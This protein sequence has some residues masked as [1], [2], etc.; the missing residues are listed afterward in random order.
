MH[1]RGQVAIFVIIAI[2]LVSSLFFLFFF[3]AKTN[4]KTLDATKKDIESVNAKGLNVHDYVQ[5]LLLREGYSCLKKIGE[6]GGYDSIPREVLIENT[7]Y[8]YYEGSNIQPFLSIIEKEISLCLNRAFLSHSDELLRIFSASKINLQKDRINSSVSIRDNFVELSVQYPFTVSGESTV[9]S[10]SAFKTSYKLN[11]KKIYELGTAVVNYATLPEFDT[12]N[13][14]RCADTQINFTFLTSNG[15]L[16]V[17]GQ[18]F[19]VFENGTVAPYTFMFGIRRPVK[20]AFG[21]GKKHI[22]ILYQENPYL[23]TFGKKATSIFQKDLNI[24]DGAD[25]FGCEDISSFFTKLD[26]YDVVVITGNLQYQIIKHTFIDSSTNKESSSGSEFPSDNGGELFYGCNSFNDPSRK[27]ALKNWVNRGG[28]L[29]I[30][31]VGKFET[32]NFIASY[33]GSLGYWGGAW[34]SIG[35]NLDLSSVQKK[36]LEGVEENREIVTKN[37]FYQGELLMCPNNISS[38]L[39]GTWMSKGLQVTN[40][41]T[42]FLGT[43]DNAKIWTRTIGEGVIVFDEFFLKDN[44]WNQLP[45]NDD[46]YSRGL[47]VKY[48]DN[49]LA[50]ISTFSHKKDAAE[51]IILINPIN[52]AI[53]NEPQ[54]TFSSDFSNDGK[55]TLTLTDPSGKTTFFRLYNFQVQTDSSSGKM[56]YTYNLTSSSDWNSLSVGRYEW[57]VQRISDE[58]TSFSNIDSFIKGG[59]F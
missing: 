48:F 16:V 35:S 33:I 29:W 45:Y 27:R 25:Y 5:G 17:K 54:F 56:L 13:P 41:D 44:L 46:I 47:A 55:F 1:I 57:Q 38:E 15:N 7:S 30:N 4:T 3:A 43:A 2:L 52:D 26:T 36:I 22:A 8:W 10:F 21:I 23:I 39:F 20:E 51:K 53:I 19:A 11:L 14:T 58:D 42:V 40:Q 59:N 32:D 24:V 34:K 6:Q 49:V 12:C 50:Y 28:I 37:E 31:D 18:T 9:S